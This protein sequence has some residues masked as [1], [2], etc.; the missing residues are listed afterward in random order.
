MQVPAADGPV[1]GDR[2]RAQLRG[3]REGEQLAPA[4]VPA[5]LPEAPEDP[6]ADAAALRSLATSDG[7]TLL[8]NCHLSSSRAQPVV[9]H[10]SEDDLADKY[11]KP[12]F[13]MS[14]VLPE[15]IR[16]AAEQER[17][18]VTADSRGFAFNADLQ[19][20]IQFLDIGTR[21]SNLR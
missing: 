13:S 9:F 17:F 3:P 4:E 20:L 11:A 14:S 15:P 5:H 8:F 2:N 6:S 7:E 19:D 1:E 10:D 16:Q 12:L 21:P 18:A